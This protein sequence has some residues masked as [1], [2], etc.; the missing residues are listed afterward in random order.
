MSEPSSPLPPAQAL[1]S[2]IRAQL[3]EGMQ[4]IVVGEDHRLLN[5]PRELAAQMASFKQ[6]GI[7]TFFTEHVPANQQP[8]LDAALA[9]K[10][11]AQRELY[12]YMLGNWHTDEAATARYNLLFAAHD[13]GIKVVG[14]NTSDSGEHM[15]IDPHMGATDMRMTMGDAY[16]TREILKHRGNAPF[17]FLVGADHV[18]DSGQ[19][20][21]FRSALGS[22]DTRLR[23]EGIPTASF[24]TV[25]GAPDTPDLVVEGNPDDRVF[26]LF[27][28][29]QPSSTAKSSLTPRIQTGLGYLRDNSALLLANS[30]MSLPPAEQARAER[31]LDRARDAFNKCASP[32]HVRELYAP[33]RNLLEQ[34][35]PETTEQDAAYYLRGAVKNV[36]FMLDRL[37]LPEN[38]VEERNAF[39][40]P[41]AAK[42]WL[43]PAGKTSGLE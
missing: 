1:G 34:H 30:G 32:A 4:G 16:M 20:R 8:L 13:A 17:L 24:V 29:E 9:G 25:I 40:G 21:I 41:E 5:L 18:G 28:A 33:V 15:M 27:T 22:I 12:S 6:A 39:C 37:S 7:N 43:R 36:G 42:N 2:F 38:G 35:I 19:N 11:E 23:A 14:V 26:S 31:Q 3:A 10:P